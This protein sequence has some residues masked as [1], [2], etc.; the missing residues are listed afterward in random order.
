MTKNY[1]FKAALNADTLDEA[2]THIQLDAMSIEELEDL[3]CMF[4]FNSGS[5]SI[6][7]TEREDALAEVCLDRLEKLEADAWKQEALK[8]E[9][10]PHLRGIIINGPQGL[11][12]SWYY[13]AQYR[14]YSRNA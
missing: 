11:S 10:D 13:R 4:A 2:L 3:A 9:T 14:K 6:P 7:P 5:S 8:H 12:A 1:D